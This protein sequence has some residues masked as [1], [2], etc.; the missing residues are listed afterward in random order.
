[1]LYK[2]CVYQL[3]MLWNAII[4]DKRHARPGEQENSSDNIYVIQLFMV[5]IIIATEAYT[6]MLS[7]TYQNN[8]SSK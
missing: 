1:M 5:C 2:M 4:E 3:N 8:D 7:I 6:F